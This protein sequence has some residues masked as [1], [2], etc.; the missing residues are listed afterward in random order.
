MDPAGRLK[1]RVG[2]FTL[3]ATP[4]MTASVLKGLMLHHQN[5]GDAT[6]LELLLRSARFLVA[7]MT[8]RQGLLRYKEPP[9]SGTN[10]HVASL[11]LLG[12]LT[13]AFEKT[14]E[15]EFLETAYRMF[16]WAVGNDETHAYLVKDLLEAVATLKAAGLLEAYREADVAE[17]LNKG[18]NAHE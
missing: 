13:F 5:T 14:G 4:F 18:T 16:R 8:N 17:H 12:P 10:P 9:I 15:A 7:N 6:A 1:D 3:G 11:M 2:T